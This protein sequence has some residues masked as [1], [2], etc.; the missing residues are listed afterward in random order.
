MLAAERHHLILDR[1]REAGVVRTVDLARDFNVAEETIRR[2]LDLLARRGKLHR[3]HGGATNPA[4]RLGELSHLERQSQEKTE[5][6]AIAREAAKLV[7]EG[8]TVLLDASSTVLELAACL[9]ANLRVATYSLAVVERLANRSDLE[10]LQ[11][12]G[13]YEARGR[14]FGGLLTENAVR[15]LRIDRF[16]FSGRGLDPKLGVSEPNQEQARLKSLILHHAAWSCA[17]IDHTKFNLRSDYMFAKPGE[18]H[19]LVTD[20]D[21]RRM[22]RTAFKSM[23]YQIHF[24]A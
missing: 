15:S 10:V 8:E 16:F 22:V 4:S 3:T 11:L 12:G 14:R 20:P 2:D 24:S 21:S 17:L 1:A 5:K 23:P 19:A 18:F 13:I 9:P 7:Q 6:T